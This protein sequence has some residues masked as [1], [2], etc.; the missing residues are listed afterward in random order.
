MTTKHDTFE[1]MGTH[2]EHLYT[3][4]TRK[5]YEVGIRILVLAL[6]SHYR[7]LEL[8]VACTSDYP[9]EIVCLIYSKIAS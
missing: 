9:I 3:I 6:P 2:E 8:G 1:T 7:N 4:K 5:N